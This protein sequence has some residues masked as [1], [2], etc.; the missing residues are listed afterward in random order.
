MAPRIS[1]LVDVDEEVC[2]ELSNKVNKRPKK[3]ISNIRIPE[4]VFIF[5]S[6]QYL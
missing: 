2:P 4:I 1:S 5:L 3:P 6:F